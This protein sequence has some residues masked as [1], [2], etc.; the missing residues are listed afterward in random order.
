MTGT[1]YGHAV[2]QDGA[3]GFA[4]GNDA[5]IADIEVEVLGFDVEKFAFVVG[6][7]VGEIDH[8]VAAT[9]SYVAV[10]AVGLKVGTGA[11]VERGGF[12][13]RINL[14]SIGQ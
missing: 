10:G 13:M 3:I 11:G 1:K 12:V 7:V 8:G 2:E 5:G 4:R 6:K 9:S 14:A